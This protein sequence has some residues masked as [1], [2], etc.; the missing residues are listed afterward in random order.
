MEYRYFTLLE[1]RTLVE[2][3]IYDTFCEPSVAHWKKF[4]KSI[5]IDNTK[6]HVKE[7]HPEI[8]PDK[9]SI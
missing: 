9:P 7:M 3:L 1:W 2:S 5:V 6:K 8:I 4:A